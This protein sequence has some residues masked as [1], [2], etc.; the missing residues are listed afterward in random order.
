[1]SMRSSTEVSVERPEWEEPGAARHRGVVERFVDLAVRRASKA[2][3]PGRGGDCLLYT[4][5]S[6]RD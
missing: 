3:E 5:P 1:M 6:P 2:D 4:S